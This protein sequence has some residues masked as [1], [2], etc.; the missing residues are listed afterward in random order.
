MAEKRFGIFVML[1]D[2][3]MKIHFIRLLK[4]IMG[5]HRDKLFQLS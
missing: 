1:L 2:I 3:K 5:S 4:G